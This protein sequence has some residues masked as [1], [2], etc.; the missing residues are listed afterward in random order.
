MSFLID[1]A[2]ESRPFARRAYIAAIAL[3]LLQTVVIGTMIVSRA[4]ILRNGSEV[5]LKASPVDPRDLLRGDY[6]ILNYDISNVPVS[7]LVGERPP[8]AGEQTLSVRLTK[9]ADGYWGIAESSFVPL[10][11]KDGTVVLASK[12]FDYRPTADTATIRVDYGIE[13]YYVPEGEGHRLEQAP[14]GGRMAIS[15]RVSPAGTAQIKALLLDNKPVYEEP[16]Y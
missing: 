7:T 12:P 3:A 15:A 16:L 14:L 4:T 11:P 13:S 8:V 5:L 1:A 9:Q 10:A 6:V 2:S